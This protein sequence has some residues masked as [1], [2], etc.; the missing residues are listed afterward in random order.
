M[1]NENVGGV[2]WSFWA[3]GTVALVFNG[4]GCMNFLSQMNAE[5]VAAMP[6]SYRAIVEAR[7]AW[8]TAAF[9]IAVFGGALGGLLLLVRRSA[10]YHVFIASLL[11]AVGTQIPFLGMAD[12]PFEAMIGGLVQL[13]VGALLIW[14]SQ[15]AER[16]GW[17]S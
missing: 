15:R 14:Y 1:N 13:V 3:I 7:P 5:T 6:E 16:K 11:G 9:A 2:H 17:I 8:A 12:F 10:A 4:L